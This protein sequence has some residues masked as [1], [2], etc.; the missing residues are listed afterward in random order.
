MSVLQKLFSTIIPKSK[1]Q[2]EAEAY[3]EAIQEE[4]KVGAKVFG[5]VPA[6]VRR[7]F[8]CLDERTWVWHEEV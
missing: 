4:A 5:P 1:D 6:G 2:V 8:F 3:R 7:E